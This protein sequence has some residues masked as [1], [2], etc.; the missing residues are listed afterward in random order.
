MPKTAGVWGRA[1]VRLGSRDQIAG[2]PAVVADTW[3][4]DK[5]GDTWSDHVERVKTAGVQV[6]R[7]AHEDLVS[8]RSKTAVTRVGGGRVRGTLLA[9]R[10]GGLGL[11]TIGGGF[12]R[13]WASKPGQ[14]FRC[15][16]DGTWR[17]RGD[18]VEQGYR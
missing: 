12:H 9:A 18:C 13:V 6:E 15:G 16:T 7:A 2:W 14:R 11:K 1:D 3:D 10:F 5:C 4:I 17:H 8:G